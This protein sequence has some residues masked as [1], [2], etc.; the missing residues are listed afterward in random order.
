[1]PS[2]TGVRDVLAPAPPYA[3]RGRQPA[4]P[5]T[6]VDRWAAAQPAAAWQALDVRDGEKGPLVVQGLRTLVQARTAG[7]VA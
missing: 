6:R 4:G 2:N 5:F 1:M 7:R 3:G